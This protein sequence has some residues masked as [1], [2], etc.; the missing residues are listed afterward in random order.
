MNTSVTVG[1]EWNALQGELAQF[2]A[3]MSDPRPLL[4]DLG[5]LQ[6]KQ[7]KDRVMQG[8]ISIDGSPYP[9]AKKT[10]TYGGTTLVGAKRGASAMMGNL[11]TMNLTRDGIEVGFDSAAEGAKALWAQDGTEAHVIRP[12]NGKALH[13]R[14][15]SFKGKRRGDVFAAVVH[16]PGTPPRRFFGISATDEAGLIR[17]AWDTVLR[18]GKGLLK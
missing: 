3:E 12:K 9:R 10:Q 11:K 17:Q 5:R 2:A 18:M 16:H 14:G 13:W 7:I 8:G 6:V 4:R 1:R 15:M